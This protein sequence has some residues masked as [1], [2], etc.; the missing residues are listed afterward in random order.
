MQEKKTTDLT[1]TSD[2]QSDNKKSR[3]T[4]NQLFTQCLDRRSQ[5][6]LAGYSLMQNLYSDTQMWD[7]FEYLHIKNIGLEQYLNQ[8]IT[9]GVA[10]S[11]EGTVFVSRALRNSAGLS[12]IS[13][14]K[15]RPLPI[16]RSASGIKLH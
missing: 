13:R 10:L 4:L 7:N 9:R 2:N 1:I 12:E 5:E 14:T 11:S 3:T 16:K 8:V 15:V 6:S